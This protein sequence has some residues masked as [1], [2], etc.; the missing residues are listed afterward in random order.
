L[1]SL[2][3]GFDEA[4]ARVLA[5]E[6]PAAGASQELVD[7]AQT[8]A[9]IRGD[10]APSRQLLLSVANQLHVRGIVVVMAEP[11]LEA[12]LFLPATAAF[13]AA[14]Y[15]PEVADAGEAEWTGALASLERSE[16]APAPTPAPA[17]EA[18]RE[19]LAPVPKGKE[20]DKDAG[21]RPFYLSPWFWGA[22]GAAALGGVALYF[23]TRDN[24]SGTIHLQLQVPK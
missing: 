6:A 4:H 15:A 17:A 24:S 21:S 13:D 3:P 1:P 8:R 22:V 12:R 16:G 19:S 23:A 5:G 18:P 2:R 7:L 9:A 10:E 20:G 11:R 14:R